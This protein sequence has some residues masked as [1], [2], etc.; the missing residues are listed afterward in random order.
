MTYFYS[1]WASVIFLVHT[2]VTDSKRPTNSSDITGTRA[3]TEE[4][5]I[6]V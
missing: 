2:Y 3:E 6:N 4:D 5:S 1:M